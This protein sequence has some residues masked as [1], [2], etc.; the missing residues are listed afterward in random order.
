MPPLTA[1][2]ALKAIRP[3]RSHNNSP[4]LFLGAVL[5]FEC[6]LAEPLL[7]LHRVARHQKTPLKSCMFVICTK[8]PA[9]VQSA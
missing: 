9:A 7:E 4:T 1:D 6:G 5:E 2:G 3:P 8:L